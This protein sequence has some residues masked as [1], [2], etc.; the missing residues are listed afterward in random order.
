MLRRPPPWHRR[1]RR[2]A[3]S[4]ATELLA[5]WPA[6]HGPEDQKEHA[7]E[8]HV[9]E[10]RSTI[11]GCQRSCKGQPG[12]QG[13]GSHDDVPAL[14]LWV[15]QLHDYAPGGRLR[16]YSAL[17]VLRNTAAWPW[18]PA[19]HPTRRPLTSTSDATMPFWFEAA[20]FLVRASARAASGESIT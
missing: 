13:Q 5:V 19:Y 4:R 6:I 1:G 15:T 12:E 7:S 20:A 8:Q 2:Q 17:K 14:I 9:D 3:L 10:L 11:R 18:S 16:R